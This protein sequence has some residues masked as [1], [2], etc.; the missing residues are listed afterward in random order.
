LI[1]GGAAL[2]AVAGE[3]LDRAWVQLGKLIEKSLNDSGGMEYQYALRARQDGLYPDVR[4]GTV[5]LKAGDVWKYGTSVEPGKRYPAAALQTLGLTMEVQSMG[6]PYQ[7]LAQE[8]IQLINYV[9]RNGDLPPGN[10][11]YK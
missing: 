1:G 7:V 10:K 2:G 11:I 6:N 4:N 8:K 3:G 5:R 9:I